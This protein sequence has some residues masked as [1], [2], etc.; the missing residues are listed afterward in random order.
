MR[1][2][3]DQE[4]V[5]GTKPHRSRNGEPNRHRVGDPTE[6]R[7]HPQRYTYNQRHTEQR[8][9]DRVRGVKESGIRRGSRSPV[10]VLI[11]EHL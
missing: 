1:A 9:R 11:G 7:E 6:A 2:I 4:L 3:E 10:R 8:E 5:P